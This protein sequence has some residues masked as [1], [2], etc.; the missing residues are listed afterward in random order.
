MRFYC[1]FLYIHL[2]LVALFPEAVPNTVYSIPRSGHF[3]T[4]KT[5]A[6][7]YLSFDI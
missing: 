1:H 2:H 3:F 7:T 6:D 4:T 5:M